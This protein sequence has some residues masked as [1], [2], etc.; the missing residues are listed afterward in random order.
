[1]PWHLCRGL[2]LPHADVNSTLSGPVIG[3]IVL[4]DV[5]FTGQSGAFR[6]RPGVKDVPL[7]SDHHSNP[8]RTMEWICV[9][10]Q[11]MRLCQI[12]S[13]VS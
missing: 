12:V 11:H 6:L 4:S 8:P 5:D 7:H 3:A 1:M 9:V 2:H 10:L 13:V